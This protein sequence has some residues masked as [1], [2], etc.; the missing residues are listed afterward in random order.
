MDL[1]EHNERMY[2]MKRKFLLLLGANQF[3]RER[4][5]IGAEKAYAGRGDV[6]TVSALAPFSP[7]KHPG[8]VLHSEETQPQQLLQDVLDYCKKTAS[9]PEAVI[10]LND[11]VLNSG[12]EIA[13]HFKLPYNSK[14]CIE[15]CRTKDLLKSSLSSEGL[16]IVYSYRFRTLDTAREIANK[17]GYPIVIKPLNFGG[18]GGIIKVYDESGLISAVNNTHEHLKKF[19][20][21]YDSDVNTMLVEPYITTKREVSV[22][23]IN[24][25]SF[26]EVIGITDKYLSDEPYFSEIGHRVPSVINEQSLISIIKSTAKKAC[27]VLEIKYGVAHVEM[28]VDIQNQKIIIIEVGPRTAGDGIM[29][30]YEKATGQ[31]IYELHVKSFLGSL[32]KDN[33]PTHFSN[34]AAICYFHPPQGFIRNITRLSNGDPFLNNVNFI[35]VKANVGQK[36]ISAQDW[37]TRYGFVEYLFWN[38]LAAKNFDLL[39]QTNQIAE[40]IFSVERNEKHD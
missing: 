33:L 19:A 40:K 14:Q 18:S 36:I 30:L 7:S 1:V 21:H 17:I 22:E 16:P 5:L 39:K 37:S 38:D 4:A 32:S 8:I 13:K 29:D 12:F 11:F 28:K 24:T 2:I 35:S 15:K 25:P 27:N 34:T 6:V 31:N 3:Q 9:V 23:V 26:C 20:E 10:P